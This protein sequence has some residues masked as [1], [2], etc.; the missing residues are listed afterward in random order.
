MPPKPKFTKDEIVAAA[1]D[2]VSRKGV[3]ALT[4]R[5][6]GQT[7]GSSARPIFTI[8]RNMEELQQEVRQAAMGRFEAYAG[9]GMPGMPLFKQV[10]MQMV[11][12]GAKEPKLYQLLFM[13]ENRSAASFDDV[14]GAL[15]A[16]ADMCIATIRQDYGLSDEDARMLFENMWIYTFGVGALCATRMCTFPVEKLGQ[17]LST[18]FQSLML[19][20]RSDPKPLSIPLETE[21]LILRE[22]TL[23]DYDALYAVL[24]DSDIMQHYPYVFDEARVKRW[25]TANQ[26]R[27]REDGFGL[28]A[29]CL[30]ETGEMIGD[31]GLTIQNINGRP[32]LEIGYHIAKAH[33][34]RGYAKEAARLCRDWAF[35]HT[36]FGTVYSYMRKDNAP[37]AATAKASGMQ[38]MEEYTDDEGWPT[39]VYGMTRQ[40][41]QSM[42][43]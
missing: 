7:L 39:L 38:L 9:Q 4:A 24:A 16:T 14:F 43:E 42:K 1:L 25:I 21:R 28:W 12:F 19:L 3:E 37:S 23:G 5:E 11:L 6:L 2:I 26:T 35:T 31:C 8:F 22:M 15:G 34:R 18:E 27:Y 13:R 10:G 33:Q 41:W 30:K 20:V 40:A 29:V 36:T 17:L 32:R